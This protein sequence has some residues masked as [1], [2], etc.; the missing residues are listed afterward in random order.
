MNLF[1]KPSTQTASSPRR[2][3]SPSARTPS[4]IIPAMAFASSPVDSPSSSFFAAAAAAPDLDGLAQAPASVARAILVALCDDR[5]VRAQ[6]L[7]QLER[8][9]RFEADVREEEEEDGAKKSPNSISSPSN[10]KKRKATGEPKI[11]V[12]CDGI[13]TSDENSF[14]SCWYHSGELELWDETQIP[15][16][17]WDDVS[18]DELDTDSNRLEY[19]A[20]FR[21]CCCQRL[22]DRQGCVRGTHEANPDRS[23]KGRG[24]ELSDLEDDPLELDDTSSQE[25]GP[26]PHQQH[27]TISNSPTDAGHKAT[28]ATMTVR[29]A[30][31]TTTTHH[32]H[33]QQ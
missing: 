22:G 33:Q 1:L 23:K 10:P 5:R 28:T 3:R 11:C 4:A 2:P 26:P 8:L 27:Y 9:L 14:G 32:H 16:T 12:Q 15:P 25:L 18:S 21:W 30:A 24:N 29:T 31:A 17:I 7:R 6:A 19:P 13:F 20:A